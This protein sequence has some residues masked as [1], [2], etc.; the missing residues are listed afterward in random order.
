MSTKLTGR[1]IYANDPGWNDSRHGFA[2]RFD[3][4]DQQPQAIVFA[5]HAEDAVNAVRWAR[6]NKVPIRVRSGRHSYEGYSSLVKGG[7]IL[8]VSELAGVSFDAETGHAVVGAGIDML[9]LT[10]KLFDVGVTIPLATGPTV[11]LG[12]LCQGGGVGITTRLLGLTCDSVVD[13]EVVTAEG[14]LVHA[15]EREHPDLYWAIRGGG[16]GNFGVVTAFKFKTHPIST[17]GI[18]NITYQWDDFVAIVDAWQKWAPFADWGLT[19]LIS[20]HTDRT[21]TIQGQYTAS[22]QDMPKLGE[23]LAPVLAIPPLSVQTMVVPALIG[24][25]ITFGVDPANPTWAILQHDDMQLFKSTSAVATELFP[26]EAI[27]RIKDGLENVPPLSAPPSQPSMVQLL[28]GGGMASVPKWSDTAVFYRNALFIVQYD[29]YWTAPQDQQPTIDWVVNLRHSMLPFASGAYVN[30]VDSQ[31][32][33]DWLEQYYGANLPRLKEI[34]K[35]Y[36]PENFFSFPQSIPL[37]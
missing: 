12:G 27:Q 28:G 7:V 21:I 34:K 29:G 14:H 23:L 25:R 4:N 31:L 1:V 11:G 6:E 2:A 19:S 9:L 26:M 35:K 10:E 3:Y 16:G 13:I 18:F 33:P 36:D 30:Y 15:N 22:P 20:L 5:Q 8:D 17:V 37:G 32:G 24:A